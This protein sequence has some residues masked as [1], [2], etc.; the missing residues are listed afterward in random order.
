[1][2]VINN[3][4][5]DSDHRRG[6]FTDIQTL[7]PRKDWSSRVIASS[8]FG[9]D[10]SRGFDEYVQSQIRQ[11]RTSAHV[12]SSTGAVTVDRMD[13]DIEHSKEWI[14]SHVLDD[15]HLQLVDHFT[16][17]L[18]ELVE[19]SDPGV[20]RS[21]GKDGARL[22]MHAGVLKRSFEEW[23]AA[24]CLEHLAT[25]RKTPGSNVVQLGSFMSK[26]HCKDGNARG[27]RRGQD[28]SRAQ[29]D[30]ALKML[31]TVG[32]TFGDQAIGDSVELLKIAVEE[33]FRLP[34]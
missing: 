1:V 10:A 34:T 17:L 33:D 15:L 2:N 31:E 32:G 26:P 25:L 7:E 27:R 13:I 14:P 21:A 28:W 5:F 16:I 19:R 22:S 29:W 3:L 23:T 6:I 20:V 9:F 4:Y 11:G 30:I 12:Q 24:D 18:K 8:I